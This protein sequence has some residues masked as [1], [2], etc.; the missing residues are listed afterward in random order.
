M[1]SRNEHIIHIYTFVKYCYAGNYFWVDTVFPALSVFVATLV[2]YIGTLNGAHL[3]HDLLLKNVMRAPTTSFFD[4]TPVGRILNRFSKDV[5]TVDNVLPM[6]LRGWITCLFAV[7]SYYVFCCLFFI[8]YE[9][10][11]YWLECV[12]LIA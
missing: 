2:L 7:L 8:S 4:I 3:L 9:K 1:L 12:C 6:T 5:D 11:L 10:Q